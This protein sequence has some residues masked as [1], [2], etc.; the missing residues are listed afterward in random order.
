MGKNDRGEKVLSCGAVLE[1][2]NNYITD[3]WDFSNNK[4]KNY[5]NKVKII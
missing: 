5:K 1:Q 4:R 3:A 2:K